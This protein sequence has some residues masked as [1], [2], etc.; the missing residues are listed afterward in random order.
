MIFGTFC[1]AMTVH[2]FFMYPETARKTLEEV[3]A[4]F[5]SNVPAWRSA[6]AT[7]GF[8]EKLEAA[9]RADGF[10]NG[11]DGLETTHAETA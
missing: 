6:K 1:I 9:Q 8:E 2:A 5:D 11:A 4:L 10:K 7:G 3:D